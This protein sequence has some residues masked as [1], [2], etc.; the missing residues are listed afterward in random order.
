[1]YIAMIFPGMNTS[2][3]KTCLRSERKKLATLKSFKS[4]F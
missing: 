1:M 2:N 3:L 4:T